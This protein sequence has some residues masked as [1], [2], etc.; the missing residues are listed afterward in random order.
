MFVTMM[1]HRDFLQ[2]LWRDG[3]DYE[4]RPT[5][6]RMSVHLF[7][8]ISSPECA[9]FGLKQA[10]NDGEAEFGTDAANFV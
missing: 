10:A 5:E 1:R 8:A 3:E 9:N 4:A 6:Y 7:G 2:F